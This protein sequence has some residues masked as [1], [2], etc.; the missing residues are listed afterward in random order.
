[1]VQVKFLQFFINA[2]IKATASLNL[3][4]Y[5]VVFWLQQL[6]IEHVVNYVLHTQWTERERS[7]QTIAWE[8]RMNATYFGLDQHSGF[9]IPSDYTQQWREQLPGWLPAGC[10]VGPLELQSAGRRL[11]THSPIMT[12][13]WITY[14]DPLPKARNPPL[15]LYL[16]LSLLSI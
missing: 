12:Q 15:P 3:N 8:C 10:P 2:T 6:G 16:S 1:M 14:T 7:A 5:H 11:S 9:N 4:V 13:G